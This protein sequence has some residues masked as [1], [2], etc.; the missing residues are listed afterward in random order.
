LKVAPVFDVSVF[1]GV[2]HVEEQMKNT[3]SYQQNSSASTRREES[4]TFSECVSQAEICCEHAR[5]AGR[6][7]RYK[8]A[9]GLFST[10]LAL[11]KR[12][13]MMEGVSYLALESRLRDVETEMAAYSELAK[14]MARPLNT[15]AAGSPHFLKRSA[16]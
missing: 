8:A 10:A 3:F 1:N 7:R 15:T 5:L 2:A 13:T 11:Y 12:A 9:Y 6:Q 16:M 14:S 4:S